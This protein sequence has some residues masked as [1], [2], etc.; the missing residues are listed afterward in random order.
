MEFS[1]FK[2]GI[3]TMLNKGNVKMLGGD[4]IELTAKGKYIAENEA[5]SGKPALVL[6]ILDRGSASIKEISDDTRLPIVTVKEIVAQ[7]I[8]KRYAQKISYGGEQ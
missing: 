1:D 4:E 8:R 7:L 5:W 2:N 6:Q 3:N